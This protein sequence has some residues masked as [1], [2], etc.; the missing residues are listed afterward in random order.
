MY[1]AKWYVTKSLTMPDCC[2]RLL[3]VP[4]F[5]VPH[6]QLP[7]DAI[8]SEQFLPPNSVRSTNK[9]RM[10]IIA[11]SLYQVTKSVGARDDIRHF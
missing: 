5:H 4:H 1:Y 9:T 7:G 10:R 2:G 8:F 3:F 6:F 11:A